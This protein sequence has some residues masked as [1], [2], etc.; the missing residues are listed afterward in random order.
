M[1]GS[2][3]YATP[4]RVIRAQTWDE[5]DGH[6]LSSVASPSTPTTKTTS[7]SGGDLFQSKKQEIED[8]RAQQDAQQTFAQHQSEFEESRD[9]LLGAID[10][11]STLLHDLRD[12]NKNKRIIHYATADDAQTAGP[13]Q[14]RHSQSNSQSQSLEEAVA[15]L[16]QSTSVDSAPRPMPMRYNTT[17]GRASLP[18]TPAR[19]VSA[20]Y[21][22]DESEESTDMSVLKLDLRVG[23]VAANPQ[24]LVR[25]LERSSVAQLLDGRMEKSERHL[26]NLKQRL[27][28]TQS[29]VLVTGDLNAGKSTFVNALL[30]RPLMPTD[31]QPCTTVFCEVL[32]ASE[33]NR[34]VEEVHM[35][36]PGV[37]YNS[38]DDSTFTRH[39][40]EEIE[41][42]VAEA[43]EVSPEDAPIL[44]CYA[45][46][47][48]ATQDSLLKNG[49]V[50]IALIDAPG[51]NRDSLKT[52]ALFA[53][54]E[55]IDVVVFVVSAE[56]HFTLS[57][58]EF[59]WNASHDKAFVFIVVN[60]FDS[61][62]NKDKCRKLVLDQIRQLSPRTYEDAANL[63][64]FVDS[65]AVF[66][67]EENLQ[68]ASALDTPSEEFGRKVQGGQLVE[69]RSTE[70]LQAFARLE[71]ALRDFVLLKRSKSKLLPSKTYMLR[72]LSDITF[73]G[74]INTQVAQ[75]ELAEAT[76][77]L[78]VA[79]PELARCQASRQKL[80]TVVEGEEDE[81][82]TGVMQEAQRKLTWAIEFIGNGKPAVDTVALPA[83]PGLFNIWEYAQE[84]RHALTSSLEL[85]LRSVEETA[86]GTASQA[87]DRVQKLGLAHLPDNEAE[88]RQRIFNPDVMFAK[89]RA[90][91]GLIGLGLSAEVVEVQV[92][93][94]FDAYH[95]F[96]IVT[97]GSLSQDKSVKKKDD[98][99]D[100]LSMLS[101]LTLGLGALTFMGGKAL[102]AKTAVDAFVRISDLVGNPTARK[103][104]GPVFAV[105]STGLVVYLIYDLPNSVPR[106]IGRSIKS[107]LQS[108]QLLRSNDTGRSDAVTTLVS[109]SSARS[110]AEG[111]EPSFAAVHSTRVG[112]ETRKVLRLASWDLQERFRVAI[113]QRR[114]EVEKQK[115]KQASANLA[116]DWF[117]K[118]TSRV[119]EIKASVDEVKGLEA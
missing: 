14:H 63:V 73:L 41:Q 99:G 5:S 4:K 42:I 84:V 59:L 48:R 89:R 82:V 45:S 106:N 61:I 46:D 32:D 23:S 12:F 47:T 16:N 10:H 58:K 31:Q 15:D 57:A 40:L 50:D 29:K 36:Q 26:E 116:I 105:V 55:E 1:S 109:S 118:T 76:K 44:K 81:A 20:S 112:R 30:R 71:A 54:Q 79:R 101:S 17:Q 6:S 113:A 86:R 88:K 72:L 13:S 39:T 56:N 37:K 34:D 38:Q 87:V 117:D 62:K 7:L 83:Y 80:E 95:H 75:I 19:Q 110:L 21:H 18:N 111:E 97:G 68:F 65:Q 9:L 104:A 28:D 66:G 60:K 119:T 77:A 93:D 70:S 24:A 25:S 74:K 102:G 43:E 53:R 107:G 35:L 90:M 3:N 96:T 100:D 98:N 64:H 69:S 78:E 51:L 33:L 103:W 11:T 67:A 94:F 92:S 114:A 22:D 2:Q 108:G 115:A 91:P 8:V 52:T 49:I 85:A 27:S